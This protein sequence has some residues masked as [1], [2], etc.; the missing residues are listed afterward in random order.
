MLEGEDVGRR[1]RW[2][3]GKRRRVAGRRRQVAGRR[4]SWEK[5][6]GGKRGKREDLN[7]RNGK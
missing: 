1:R 5:K 7:K 6:N 3:V 2:V 4:R